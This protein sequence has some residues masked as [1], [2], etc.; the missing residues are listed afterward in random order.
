MLRFSLRTLLVAVAVISVVVAYWS[1]RYRIADR[2]LTKLS[3]NDGGATDGQEVRIRIAGNSLGRSRVVLIQH[4][5]TPDRQRL[6]LIPG[7]TYSNNDPLPNMKSDVRLKLH[8]P[9][10]PA[11]SGVW[12]DGRE[13]ELGSDLLVLYVSDL[14][15]AERL[16][17]PA[18]RRGDFLSDAASL[19]PI[20]FV[21]KWIEP[22]RG[23]TRP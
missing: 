22:N 16:D 8:S 2:A 11:V 9:P 15:V 10:D 18:E 14:A 5:A 3:V 21:K 1:H 23:R 4:L 17:V 13:Q 7:R 20:Q 19:D 12:I 6:K